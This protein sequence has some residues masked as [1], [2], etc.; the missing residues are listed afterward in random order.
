MKHEKQT[1]TYS[2]KS[3]IDEVSQELNIY[4]SAI[5]EVY[6][7]IE[8]TINQHLLEVEKNKNVEVKLFNGMKI[9]SK[10][11]KEHYHAH[12]TTGYTLVPEKIKFGFNFSRM[13]N[14]NK[15]NDYKESRKMLT[16]YL[17][18]REKFSTDYK[19]VK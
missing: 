7:C 9:S 18:E 13:Y 6:N 16:E 17:K 5:E 11:V 3:I 14:E 2:K 1:I 12:P 10:I 15:N 8:K 19:K 4:P